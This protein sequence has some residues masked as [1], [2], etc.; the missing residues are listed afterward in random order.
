[1]LL[2]PISS[3]M[4]RTSDIQ[5]ASPRGTVCDKD[6]CD[7]EIVYWPIVPHIYFPSSLKHQWNLWFLESSWCIDGDGVKTWLLLCS[8]YIALWVGVDCWSFQILIWKHYITR[9]MAFS[10]KLR[11]TMSDWN[12]AG[13]EMIWRGLKWRFSKF[14]TPSWCSHSLRIYWQL[15]GERKTWDT[16]G[17]Q[18]ETGDA[19]QQR[20]GCQ[21]QAP[22]SSK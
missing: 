8:L 18:R 19:C 3:R 10:V 20:T 22:G 6:E 21:C 1:M 14:L 13:L 16:L 12:R 17:Q 2:S 9:Q 4:C 7:R 11:P 5:L 15:L